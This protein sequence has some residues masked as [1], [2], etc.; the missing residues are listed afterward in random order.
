MPRDEYDDYADAVSPVG[1]RTG[2]RTRAKGNGGPFLG[3]LWAKFNALPAQTKVLIIGAIVVVGIV[4]YLNVKGKSAAAA[5]DTATSN[6]IPGQKRKHDKDKEQPPAPQPPL[7]PL[8]Q[9]PVQQWNY[10]PLGI[11][12]SRYQPVNQSGSVLGP[13]GVVGPLGSN[14]PTGPNL[15]PRPAVN[16]SM[17]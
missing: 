11:L 13:G 9:P 16:P 4:I 7:Q 8:V 2:T 6:Q 17:N 14:G 10:W 3:K 15:T 5:D 12:D 1:E